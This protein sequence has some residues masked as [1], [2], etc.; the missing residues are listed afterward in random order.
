MLVELTHYITLRP[1]LK[2]RYDRW[3]ALRPVPPSIAWFSRI[4]YNRRAAEGGRRQVDH[5]MNKVNFP[6]VTGRLLGYHIEPTIQGWVAMESISMGSLNL[7][8]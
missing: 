2:A 4:E 6:T 5:A 3:G 8:V 7:E 1:Q